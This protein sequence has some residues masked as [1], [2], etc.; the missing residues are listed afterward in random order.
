M[1]IAEAPPGIEASSRRVPDLRRHEPAVLA[2][3]GG[4]GELRG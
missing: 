1:S 3:L 2:R 4:I